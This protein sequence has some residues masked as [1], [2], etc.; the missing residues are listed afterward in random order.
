MNNRIPSKHVFFT[1]H[2]MK[3]NTNHKANNNYAD[4]KITYLLDDNFFEA[5]E[6]NHKKEIDE[7]IYT[8]DIEEMQ[9]ILNI[10]EKTKFLTPDML[11]S[12]F[13]KN[14]TLEYNNF[15][16]LKL[17]SIFGGPLLKTTY[18]VLDNKYVYTNKDSYIN[19]KTLD[20]FNKASYLLCALNNNNNDVNIVDIETQLN[21]SN[22]KFYTLIKVTLSK[23]NQFKVVNI[24]LNS[25]DLKYYQDFD[26]G[27]YLNI[28]KIGYL[29]KRIEIIL[30]KV[31]QE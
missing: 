31:F 29:L 24:I 4:K 8:E 27:I 18:S 1:K 6:I 7:Q 30:D 23:N 26:E 28:E 10:I 12:I 3:N 19:K 15:S 21:Y 25:D 9:Y 20:G 2:N 16:L 22:D 17:A 14:K 11:T 13:N 5:R